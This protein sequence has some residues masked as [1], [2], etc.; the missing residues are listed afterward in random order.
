MRAA[1][2]IPIAAEIPPVITKKLVR[3]PPAIRPKPA[4][5]LG[6]SPI[7]W[8]PGRVRFR[9]DGI[10]CPRHPTLERPN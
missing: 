7:R 4:R 1:R 3:V 2:H 9:C 6:F 8:R 5:R 10:A